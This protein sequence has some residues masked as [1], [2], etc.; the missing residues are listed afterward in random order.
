MVRIRP[1][2]VALWTVILLMG[3]VL[4]TLRGDLVAAHDNEAIH[5]VSSDAATYYALYETLYAEADLSETPTLLLI[6]SPILFMKVAGGQLLLVQAI[7][8]IVMALTLGVAV[9]C[10][11]TFAGRITFLFGALVFPYFLFGFLSLNKEIYAMCSAIFFASYM[12]RGRVNHLVIALTL[13][14]CARYYLLLALLVLPILVPRNGPPRW[15]LIVGLLLSISVMAPIAK[16]LVPGYSGEDV[17]DVAGL[18]G[19]FFSQA[20][21]HYGYALVYPVKYVALIPARAYSYLIG[22]ERAG[23]AMEALVSLASLAVFVMACRIMLRKGRY[24]ANPTTRR[25]IVAAFVAPMPLMW[26]EIMHWR[27]YSFVYFFFLV[28][29]V[30]HSFDHKRH[31]SL[32]APNTVHA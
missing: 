7:N 26:S 15:L 17:T 11:A 6:G 9:R 14:A 30:L 21:D 10:F 13:G 3:F 16:D 24:R 8:L 27:Y 18:T 5:Y 20:I 32:P 31:R 4:I 12:V 23:D 19:R 29:I 25:L 22:S 1:S 2:G 28:A